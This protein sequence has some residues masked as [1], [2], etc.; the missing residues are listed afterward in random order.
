MAGVAMV[1]TIGYIVTSHA[2][3]SGEEPSDFSTWLMA[4]TI[5]VCW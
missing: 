1:A 4:G 3:H 5:E 2:D